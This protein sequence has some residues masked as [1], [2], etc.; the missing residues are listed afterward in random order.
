MN[1]IVAESYPAL[2]LCLREDEVPDPTKHNDQD[3]TIKDSKLI[4]H[5]RSKRE[6]AHIKKKGKM[7]R[8]KL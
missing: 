6:E 3:P 1:K 4:S 8:K 2:P 5:V 7:R